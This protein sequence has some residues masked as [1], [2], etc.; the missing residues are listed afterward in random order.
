MYVLFRAISFGCIWVLLLVASIVMADEL[1]GTTF[2]IQNST[3]NA[4]G[5]SG[6]STT[7]LS[8]M[9]ESEIETNHASSTNFI[10]LMGPLHFGMAEFVTQNWRW[11]DDEENETPTSALAGENVAPIDINQEDVIALRIAVAEIAGMDRAAAKLRVQF[12]TTSD[13]AY[14]GYDLAESTECTAESV[15]CYADGAAADNARITTKLLSDVDACSGSVGVGCGTHNESATSSATET[16]EAS[17]IAEYQFTIR[18][19]GAAQ[20]TVYFFRLVDGASSSTIPLNTGE[21]YP[22]LVS[23]GSSL[24]FSIGG[25]V[26]G[27]VTEGVTTD[28]TTTP[29]GIAF[30]TLS[31]NVATEG[32]QRMT[33]STN[34]TQGYR[35][36]LFQRQDFLSETSSRIDPVTGT[37]V[38]PSAWTTGCAVEASGCFGYHSGDDVL[39]AESGATRFAAN[40]TYAEATS[41]PYTI[42]FHDAPV[43]NQ[44]TDVIY[45]IETRSDQDDGDYSTSLVYVVA[46]VF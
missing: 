3:I 32:A 17:A 12:S 7:F 22:S 35:I 14:G 30:G 5:G 1:T 44:Q 37:N 23:G 26:S 31:E 6:T 38:A 36:Y 39:D 46:P 34:G 40:D 29:T 16:H 21:S 45:R 41:T 8:E 19:S 27:V 24:N 42:A 4:F 11:Y 43:S 33:V 13:F 15:F 10:L 2:S 28:I 25:L 9:A 20:N 18:Q